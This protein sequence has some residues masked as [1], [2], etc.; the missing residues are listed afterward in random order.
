MSERPRRVFLSLGANLG[1]RAAALRAA[2]DALADL[3]GTILLATSPIYQTMPR[4]VSGQPVFLNQVV[5]L[6]TTLAPVDLLGRCQ[7]IEDDAG[8]TRALRFGPRTLDIDILLYEG[9]E[10]DAPELTL[11]HPRMWQRAFVVVPL[12][13][14][15]PLAREMPSVDVAA[16][17][18]ELA[19]T[20]G[21]DLYPA[22]E[23]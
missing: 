6:E 20:Q 2:R 17:A 23:D 5:C 15:W 10:S 11:P 16:L 18:Q 12:S 3:P 22:A 4:E 1:E 19:S 14:L 8:R 9:V 7:A 21:V 13:A